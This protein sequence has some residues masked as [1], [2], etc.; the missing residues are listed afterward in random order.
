[1][2]RLLQVVEAFCKKHHLLEATN[3]VVVGV[4]GGPD[5]VCLLHLLQRIAL[6]QNFRLHVAHLNHKLRTQAAEEDA[7]FVT[8]LAKK[9]HIAVT[10][11]SIDV[12]QF[13]QANKLNLEDA[14]RYCRYSFLGQVAEDIGTNKIAVAHH[15][16]DQAETVLMHLL[17]GAGTAG[18]SGMLPKT[19]L[20]N[21]IVNKALDPSISAHPNQTTKPPIHQLPSQAVIRPLLQITKA[22]IEAYCQ[23]HQLEYRIDS[24]NADTRLQRNRIR[25]EMLPMLETYNPNVVKALTQTAS[26]VA[27]DYALIQKNVDTAWESIL[28]ERTSQSITLSLTPYQQLPHALQSAILRRG[29]QQVYPGVTDIEYDHVEAATTLINKGRVNTKLD[30]PHQLQLRVDYETFTLSKGSYVPIVSHCPRLT[31]GD[32]MLSVT[33]PGK[34]KVSDEW[35]IVT[36]LIA[37]DTTTRKIWQSACAWQG[38]FD[39]DIVGTNLT[40]R[41]RLPGDKFAPLGQNGHYQRVKTF[42][43]NQKIP[44]S[45]RR[46][47]PLLTDSITGEIY[48]IC[49]YRTAQN[50]RI[51]QT[52]RR[53]LFVEFELH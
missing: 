20:D 5:S 51:T 2:S 48:W 13:A 12:A 34:T 35:S 39:A 30:L 18:L 11:Q 45:E 42:M 4:S 27:A 40:L 28:A 1:M 24:S 49:G 17:R 6:A 32:T 52:T 7:A 9:W 23:T 36:K 29:F 43:I 44:V 3:V 19:S 22:D 8:K 50:G 25:H 47:I 21:L 38:Y 10:I 14:A 15:A 26:I 37:C 33:V 31:T 46:D 53:V 16:N 41:T